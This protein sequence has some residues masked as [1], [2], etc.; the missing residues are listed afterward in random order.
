MKIKLIEHYQDARQ[1]L[2]LGDEVF[3]DDVLGQWLLDNGKAQRLP[4][5]QPEKPVE[6]VEIPEIPKRRSK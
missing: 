1:T 3:V 4:E 5:P 2:I 6:V